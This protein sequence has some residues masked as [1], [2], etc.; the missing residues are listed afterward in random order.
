[1]T[2][3]LP[4]RAAAKAQARALRQALAD[5]GQPISHGQALD[6]L[7]RQYGFR[8]W[9]T[10]SA[11]IDDSPP[12]A[13]IPGGRIT[14]RYL[15]QPFTATILSVGN[16]REGWFRVVL[17]LDAPVDVVVFESFSNLRKRIRGTVDAD[18][19]S[20]ETT[21]DGTPHLVLNL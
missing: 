4:S 9:N 8:D 7:A 19:R 17:D 12:A 10:L 20:R 18:G 6:Q 3:A 15:S 5:Q 14:G 11:A 2:A 13:L 21:S 1:M 16:P